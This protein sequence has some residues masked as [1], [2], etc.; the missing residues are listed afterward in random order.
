MKFLRLNSDLL[1]PMFE[2]FKKNS[3]EEL[4]FR[5]IF[6]RFQ[7]S[8]VLTKEILSFLVLLSSGI[9]SLIFATFLMAKPF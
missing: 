6:A 3:V 8:P 2:V 7:Y 1:I 5:P 4:I 9:E